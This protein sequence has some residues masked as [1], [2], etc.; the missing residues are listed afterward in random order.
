[1]RVES[2]WASAQRMGRWALPTLL[3]TAHANPRRPALQK[4]TVSHRYRWS[5]AFRSSNN[6][7]NNIFQLIQNHLKL[8]V[9]DREFHD[10]WSINPELYHHVIY[11]STIFLFVMIQE[12]VESLCQFLQ[13][14]GKARAQMC[15]AVSQPSVVSRYPPHV[16]CL[17]CYLVSSHHYHHPSWISQLRYALWYRPFACSEHSGGKKQDLV[18]QKV[19]QT[20]KINA[21]VQLFS[22]NH[23]RRLLIL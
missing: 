23:F 17:T 13:T 4:N 1:M 9:C 20:I 11:T 22:L 16:L 5:V 8:E 10:I 14:R 3:I 19:V 21:R 12:V 15:R 7:V 2:M 18:A 6:L